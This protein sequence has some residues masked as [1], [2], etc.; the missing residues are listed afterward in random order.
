MKST[1]LNVF[2]LLT[3][4][5]ILLATGCAP[6][7]F[8]PVRDPLTR[9]ESK[10]FS[11]LP[12]AGSGWQ[13]RQADNFLFFGKNLGSST[14]T[15]GISIARHQNVQPELAGYGEY[16][17]NPEI[18]AAYVKA[19]IEHMNVSGR[20]QISELTVVPDTRF[21]Y[22]AKFHGKMEDQGSPVTTQVLQ[23]ED[24]GYSCLSPSHNRDIIEVNF[25]ERGLPGESEPALNE[26][27][28]QLFLGLQLK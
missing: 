18:F 1:Y 17:T 23:Q 24:Y 16:A 26:V 8:Q 10:K 4:L 11:V 6:S 19:S 22:C 13:M 15:V 21:G 25:S 5:L 7:G 9:I 12:P 28:E 14:H 2:A 3:I 27:R 20:M